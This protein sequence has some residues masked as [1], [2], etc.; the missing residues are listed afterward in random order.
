M[1]VDGK[2]QRIWASSIEVCPIKSL[3]KLESFDEKSNLTGQL[4]RSL[5]GTGLN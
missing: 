5:S 4:R 1:S 2:A 3:P